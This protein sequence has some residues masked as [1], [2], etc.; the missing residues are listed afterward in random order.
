M[1]FIRSRDIKRDQWL[2]R[3]PSRQFSMK[4]R[5]LSIHLMKM[6]WTRKDSIDKTGDNTTTI[7]YRISAHIMK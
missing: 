2:M 4:E 1:E 6:K 5:F 7:I 3:A